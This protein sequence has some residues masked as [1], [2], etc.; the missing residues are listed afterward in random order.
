MSADVI[1]TYGARIRLLNIA[2]FASGSHALDHVT[3]STE[4]FL[5]LESSQGGEEGHSLDWFFDYR[6]QQEGAVPPHFVP[7]EEI[8]A[9]SEAI[10]A[11]NQ[12]VKVRE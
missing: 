11:E 2:S 5:Q 3:C 10:Q 8:A 9:S 7:H 1:S 4:S 12:F 6:S